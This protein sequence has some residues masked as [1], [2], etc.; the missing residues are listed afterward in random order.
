MGKALP[1]G[2]SPHSREISPGAC[3]PLRLRDVLVLGASPS[4]RGGCGHRR[5]SF[6]GQEVP[7]EETSR[8]RQRA[9]F[10][11]AM[12]LR[13][14]RPFA[15]ETLSWLSILPVPPCSSGLG[16]LRCSS[17]SSEPPSG[18]GPCVTCAS[19]AASPRPALTVC[20]F[21]C[22][23][24]RRGSLCA[25]LPAGCQHPHVH[26]AQEAWWVTR[27]RSQ[28]SHMGGAFHWTHLS[29]GHSQQTLGEHPLHAK[30]CSR[31]LG[32]KT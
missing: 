30:S 12:V 32:K 25:M 13:T 26:E 21:G 14:H 19:S 16:Q 2:S 24:M 3:N 18:L 29:L 4:V 20:L 5:E 23:L 28:S 6:L 10:L 1:I 15:R 8:S 27:V 31:L 11:S 22:T 17:G 9:I 7:G